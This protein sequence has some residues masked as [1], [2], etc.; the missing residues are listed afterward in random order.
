MISYLFIFWQD[1]LFSM[2]A[3]L[4]SGLIITEVSLQSEMNGTHL[5]LGSFNFG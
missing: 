4:F 2:I 1:Q 5:I 3:S